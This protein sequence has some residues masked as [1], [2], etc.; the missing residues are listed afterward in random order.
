M[1]DFFPYPLFFSQS[2][3][4]WK[5]LCVILCGQNRIQFILCSSQDVFTQCCAGK[6][7]FSLQARETVEGL[8]ETSCT[9]VLYTYLCLCDVAS[10]VA[11]TT[12][13]L[14]L[15]DNT[16]QFPMVVLMTD[17]PASA[18]DL[19]APILNVFTLEF[20]FFCRCDKW[21]MSVFKTMFP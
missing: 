1:S 13:V 2:T 18:G 6:A 20:F 19:S 3:F 7:L 12:Y 11:M 10:S 17:V 15:W 4:F 14:A 21:I 5:V 8:C 9:H 16:R